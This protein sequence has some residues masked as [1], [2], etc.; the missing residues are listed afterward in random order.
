MRSFSPDQ[1]LK[2]LKYN[3][4]ASGDTRKE[5][6]NSNGKTLANKT[7]MVYNNS[8]IKQIQSTHMRNSIPVFH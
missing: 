7:L 2:Y 5:Q 4:W 3:Q 1:N 6:E 8:K